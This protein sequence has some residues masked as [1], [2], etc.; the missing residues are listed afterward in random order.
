M[1]YRGRRG[2]VVFRMKIW[3]VYIRCRIVVILGIGWVRKSFV[4]VCF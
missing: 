3:I 1:V 2:W 4:F